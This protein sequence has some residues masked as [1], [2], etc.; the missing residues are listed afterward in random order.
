MPASTL[1]RG[2]PGAMAFSYVKLLHIQ[3]LVCNDSGCVSATQTRKLREFLTQGYFVSGC[4]DTWT[5]LWN[6]VDTTNSTDVNVCKH[7]RETASPVGDKRH[8]SQF[9]KALLPLFRDSIAGG[10]RGG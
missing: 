4:D 7:G 6:L 9:R 2:T 1:C 3:G 8:L 10:S 5:H